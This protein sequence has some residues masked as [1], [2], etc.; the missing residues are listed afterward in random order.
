MERM[1]AVESVARAR[2]TWGL[3]ARLSL[4]AAIALALLGVR[5]SSAWPEPAADAL[6]LTIDYGDGVELS[7]TQLSWRRG[8]TALDL[9]EAAAVHPRGVTYKHSGSGSTAFIMEIAGL[10]NKGAGADSRNWLF[11]VNSKLAEVGCGAYLVQPGDKIV[12]S[13]SKRK[14]E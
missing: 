12:W 3:A 10:K 8:L 7:F 4:G 2:L 9:L 6:R 13:Y 1:T 11:S 14:P 5:S